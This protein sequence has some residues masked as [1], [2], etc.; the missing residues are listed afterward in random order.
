MNSKTSSK[1]KEIVFKANKE[2]KVE[3]GISRIYKETFEMSRAKFTRT[4]E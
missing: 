4:N 1:V 3:E 2:I